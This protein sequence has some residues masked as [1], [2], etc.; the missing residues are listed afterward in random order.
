MEGKMNEIINAVARTHS[1]T[2]NGFVRLAVVV[3]ENDN[4]SIDIVDEN[5]QLIMRLNIF[6]HGQGHPS[7]DIIPVPG[8]DSWF[9][10]QTWKDGVTELRAQV[11]RSLV[12]VS[13]LK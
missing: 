9:A 8:E 2:N 10:V 11:L 13:V 12:S 6:N 3:K 7:V 5:G 1:R 4:E